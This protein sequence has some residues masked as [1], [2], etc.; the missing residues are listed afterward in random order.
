MNIKKALYYKDAQLFLDS[1]I[2]SRDPVNITAMK[3]DGSIL[4]MNGWLVTSGHWK[5]RT[6]NFRNPEN[7]QI[8]KI[9]DILIFKINNH[10]VYL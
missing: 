5:S 4:Q 9:R 6:H 8:R 10:P 7:G 2:K 3:S 1:C